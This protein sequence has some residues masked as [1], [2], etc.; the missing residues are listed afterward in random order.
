M[1]SLVLIFV[2]FLILGLVFLFSGAGGSYK[3]WKKRWFILKGNTISYYKARGD[4]AP[5]GTIYVE[6]L[7]AAE[8]TNERKKPH[9]FALK[10]KDNEA[11]VYYMCADSDEDMN[12]WI[13]VINQARTRDTT[14]TTAAQKPSEPIKQFAT[15]EW[16]VTNGIRIV[17]DVHPKILRAL[18]HGVPKEDKTRDE[19]G[20]FVNRH[21]PL[22]T[23]LNIFSFNGWNVETMY[24]SESYYPNNPTP[25]DIT[26]VVLWKTRQPTRATAEGGDSAISAQLKSSNAF[27][28]RQPVPSVAGPASPTAAA[29]PLSSTVAASP[30]AKATPP[31]KP[32][33]PRQ[34]QQQQQ[35]LAAAAAA[36]ATV[37]G[38]SAATSGRAPNAAGPTSSTAAAAAMLSNDPSYTGDVHGRV[39]APAV[40]GFRVETGRER[41]AND[42]HDQILIENPELE[43]CWYSNYF[44]GRTHSNFVGFEEEEGP[45]VLSVIHEV[46]RLGNPLQQQ[47]ST[48]LTHSYQY[49]TIVWRT[50]VIER[51]IVPVKNEKETLSPSDLLAA[52]CPS[53]AER[54]GIK[55]REVDE[56]TD[57]FVKQLVAMEDTITS[58]RFKFGALYAKDGQL[59]DNDMF[60]NETGSKSFDDFMLALG[61]KIELANWSKF[62]A[63]LDT[64]KGMTGTHSIYTA[65][66]GYEIMFHV[67][68]M[69]PYNEADKQQLERK[70]HIGNDIATIVFVDGT[71]PFSPKAISS[72][73]LH[74]FAVV[75]PE[76]VVADVEDLLDAEGGMTTQY[77]VHVVSSDKVPKFGPPVPNPPVFRSGPAM[78][79]FLLAKLINGE[80]STY[81]SDSF[82][83][84]SVR[85]LT[86]I[87]KYIHEKYFESGSKSSMT[88]RLNITPQ[89]VYITNG[90]ALLAEAGSSI[91][92]PSTSPSAPSSG[93]SI[94]SMRSQGAGETVGG[95]T[96]SLFSDLYTVTP[97]LA[98]FPHEILC[99]A[100]LSDD[101]ILLGTDFGLFMWQWHFGSDVKEIRTEKRRSF[102]KLAVRRDLNLL[103]ALGC[104]RGGHSYVML[105]ALDDILAGS[106]KHGVMAA[107]K[108]RKLSHSRGC[109]VM[110]LLPAE[111]SQNVASPAPVMHSTSFGRPSQDRNDEHRPILCVATRKSVMMYNWSLGTREF[112][113]TRELFLP[114]Q[115]THLKFSWQGVAVAVGGELNMLDM[116]TGNVTTSILPQ[117][118]VKAGIQS[119]TK[120]E[121]NSTLQVNY[122]NLTTFVDYKGAQTRDLVIK[123]SAVPHGVVVTTSSHLLGFTNNTI[124]LRSLLNGASLQAVPFQSSVVLL[125]EENA[126]YVSANLEDEEGSR[127]SSF[128]RIEYNSKKASS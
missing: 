68:T 118:G 128:Y 73:F 4:A 69:L 78:R 121:T 85:T 76:V 70:R 59:K 41:S 102:S 87:L 79:E 84:R 122:N 66:R 34:Q 25:K 35:Q 50:T 46:D 42:T 58:K 96:T 127:V 108:G 54:T 104:K 109:V 38:S 19:R 55:L 86:T 74:V 95:A 107:C 39:L 60:C 90:A 103:A 43:V 27:K 98:D 20:W 126:I 61:D 13:R 29:A 33:P 48:H 5:A 89:S 71:T 101:V 12:D 1:V 62:R 91:N 56:L 93:V 57:D 67:S 10:S 49:R 22:S 65:Y 110:D 47:Q 40:E 9:C 32:A 15:A 105:Y 113:R 63:G 6:E 123:W 120:G 16:F 125:H 30:L 99:A 81:V 100:R 52:A 28:S 2:Q 92:P 8:P 72:H 21:L 18:G 36:V 114:E 44:K 24:E 3:S 75:Q 112:V 117:A 119:I 17:G 94:T 11:R 83:A 88:K 53:L 51:I 14:R 26:C 82:Q 106:S 64:K 116:E 23:L 77:R 115:C 45:F 124:E 31:P 37:A 80:T 97:L 7:S 111:V